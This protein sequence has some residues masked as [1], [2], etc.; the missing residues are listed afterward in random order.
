MNRPDRG[1]LCK[2]TMHGKWP[3]IT[4]DQHLTKLSKV[5]NLVIRMELTRTILIPWLSNFRRNLIINFWR[6]LYL[7]TC[8]LRVTVSLLCRLQAVSKTHVPIDPYMWL[9]KGEENV[10]TCDRHNNEFVTLRKMLPNINT[11]KNGWSSLSENL[12]IVALKLR[13]LN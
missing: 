4:A 11:C 9:V 6:F 8:F 1:I 5:V 12:R 3:S 7:I 10:R 13:S 2:W